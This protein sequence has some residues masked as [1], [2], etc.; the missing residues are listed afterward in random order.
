MMQALSMTSP[1]PRAHSPRPHSPRSPP[2]APAD[3]NAR[4]ARWGSAAFGLPDAQGVPPGVLPDPKVRSDRSHD[5]LLN[6]LGN[7]TEK[8]DQLAQA[9]AKLKERDKD[10]ANGQLSARRG[11]RQER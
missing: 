7:L 10:M 2:F 5:L 1:R 9:M 11:S 4:L 8:V 3:P 6:K